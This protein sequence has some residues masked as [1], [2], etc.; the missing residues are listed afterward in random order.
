MSSPPIV[1]VAGAIANKCHNGGEAWVRLSWTLGFRKLGCTVFLLEQIDPD[2]CVDVAGAPAPF[3][4]SANLAFFR[5][6]TRRFGLEG[7]AALLCGEEAGY[8]PEM[9]ELVDIVGSADLFVNISGNV[10][11]AVL[12]ER[13]R[14][15]AYVDIDPGFTQFWN[16][17]QL[18]GGTTARH[19][20][21]FTIGE[22][23]GSPDC[24]IPS[25]G[26]EWRPI[27]QPALLDEWPLCPG[28]LDRFTTVANWRGPYA[29]IEYEGRTYGV[30][31]HEFRKV[32]PLP[33]RVPW[34]FELALNIHPA[35]G[36]DLD[37]LHAHGWRT[38]D[39]RPISGDPDAF[40]HYIQT[41]GAEFSVAQGVYVGTESGWFSDRTVRYLASGKP[42][43]VQETGFSQ[44]LPSG[45][46]LLSF[47][48]LD[49]AVDGAARI[50]RDYDGHC[51]AARAIAEEYFD[52]DKVLARMLEET[53][54]S[55]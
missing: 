33:Q 23:I 31:V 11:A 24:P 49:E 50:A 2:A 51:Q 10:T 16:T 15:T 21:Y 3:E 45:E 37:S 18:E 47:R 35:D 54:V 22:N 34:T 44:H 52:S 8:G 55:H 53:G 26:I 20:H 25:G 6:I 42:A 27:R 14:R 29:A 43:L 38:V 48:T 32:F 5:D 12:L 17:A 41:S 4:E 13:A 40:R 9:A 7:S 36:R 1:V 46:G 19:D 30:K 28:S 39:P